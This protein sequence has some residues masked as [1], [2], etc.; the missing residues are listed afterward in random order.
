MNRPSLKQAVVPKR[1]G[2]L[3]RAAPNDCV[4]VE[5]AV[6]HS[7]G[8]CATFRALVGYHDVGMDSYKP[9]EVEVVLVLDHIPEQRID[10][11]NVSFLAVLHPDMG[12]IPIAGLYSFSHVPFLL[13]S[14]SQAVEPPLEVVDWDVVCTTNAMVHQHPEWTVAGIACVATQVVEEAEVEDSIHRMLYAG[15]SPIPNQT[16]FKALFQPRGKVKSLLV[17]QSLSAIEFSRVG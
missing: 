7:K 6:K 3:R 4:V 2:L 13:H 12:K 11:E 8:F 16:F 14:R 9:E 17:W 5:N 15:A 10:S 1:A